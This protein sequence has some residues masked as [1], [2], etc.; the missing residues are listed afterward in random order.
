MPILIPKG[1]EFTWTPLPR[2]G[3]QQMI[4]KRGFR[5]W[6]LHTAVS[7]GRSIFN[8]FKNSPDGVESTAYVRKDGTGEQYMWV[9]ERAD[10]Q[11]DG[12]WWS[13]YGGS[14]FASLESWDGAGTSIWPDWRTNTSHCPPWNTAQIESITDVLAW[15]SRENV[16]N[17]PIQKA[18]GPRGY[19]I[20]YHAQYTKTSP[21]EWNKSHA[22]PA[23]HRIAQ[24]PGIIALAKKKAAPVVAVPTK[25]APQPAPKPVETEMQISDQL[26]VP[27][28]QKEQWPDDKGIADGHIGVSTALASGYGHSRLAQERTAEI[29]EQVAELRKQVT[30]L[31]TAVSK[32]SGGAS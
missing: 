19:G 10:C 21:Y 24:V 25:P 28:W 3:H 26:V 2:H 14:G 11:M 5:G 15:S 17:Y 13:E 22:C 32:L 27:S 12:N 29:L 4:S 18:T 20:G 31:T 7:N 9:D 23:P 30:A 1:L 6:V 8:V 16:L